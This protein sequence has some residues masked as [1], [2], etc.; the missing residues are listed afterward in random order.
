MHGI[1]VAASLMILGLA[2]LPV[3]VRAD[4]GSAR[5]LPAAHAAADLREGGYVL[6]PQAFLSFCARHPADCAPAGVSQIRLDAATMRTLASV[7]DGVNA[8][9]AP[10]ELRGKDVWEL[11]LSAGHCAIFAVQKRHD[12]IR[13]GLPA[14]A[15]SLAVVTT[16]ANSLHLVLVVRTDHGAIV[17]DNLDRRIM[18]WTATRYQYRRVQ[19]RENPMLWV[20]VAGSRPV[21]EAFAEAEAG[22]DRAAAG[23]VRRVADR[24][25]VP[26]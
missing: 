21:G 26:N 8:R 10:V 22:G 25:A 11:G 13:K 12:L 18:P 4:V 3:D 6:A 1:A 15:L 17:L 23:L 5:F 20:S 24:P 14:D 19:S 7:N 16:R 2:G 9:V